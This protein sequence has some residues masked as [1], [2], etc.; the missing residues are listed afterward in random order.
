MSG[1]NIKLIEFFQKLNLSQM[2]LFIGVGR[3]GGGGQGG[4]PPII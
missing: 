2:C 3:G 4:H 1:R